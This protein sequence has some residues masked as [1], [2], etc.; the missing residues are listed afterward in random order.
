MRILYHYPLDPAS[1]QARIALGERKLKFKL[2]PV[3]PWALDE[4]FLQLCPEGV[5]PCLVEDS[6]GNAFILGSHRAIC[7]YM[8][9]HTVKQHSWMADTPRERAECRRL[10]F[11]MDIKFTEEVNAY[12]LSERL[13]KTFSGV[14]APDPAELRMGRDH[15]KI[16]L[17]YFSQLL[18]QRSWIAGRS[19]SLADIAVAAHISCLD[20]LGEIDWP[21]WPLLQDWYQKVKCRPAFRPILKDLIP[22]LRPP[23]HYADLDF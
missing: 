18:E 1:R 7:E 19:Y 15:L 17:E 5:P 3:T 16:H 12:I 8:A 10:C 11:W 22:G 13:E 9:D 4:T 21:K 23:R 6:G 14:G 2:Q 20:Y